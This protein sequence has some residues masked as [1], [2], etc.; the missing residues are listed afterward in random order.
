MG[1]VRERKEG[2]SKVDK[3]GGREEE[4]GKEAKGEEEI[5]RREEGVFREVRGKREE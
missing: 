3:L 1:A 2:G 5:L 4:R